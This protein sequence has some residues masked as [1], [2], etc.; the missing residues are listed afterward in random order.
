MSAAESFGEVFREMN[1]WGFEPVAVEPPGRAWK[2]T[3]RCRD[4][5]ILIE[6]HV[7]DWQFIQYPKISV[8]SAFND[9]RLRPHLSTQRTLCY[10]QE[11]A[12]VLD[13]H[14]PAVAL[15]QC[16]AQAQSVLSRL[17]FDTDSMRADLLEEFETYWL[18]ETQ[19][20][21]RV[22]LASVPSK[23]ASGFWRTTFWTL[24]YADGSLCILSDN[25]AE[26]SKISHSF[27]ASKFRDTKAPCWLFSTAA[28]PAIPE[29]LPSTVKELFSWLRLWDAE[30]YRHFQDLLGHEVDYIKFQRASFAITSPAGWL[31]FSF[32]IDVP[33][34]KIAKRS[35]RLYRNFLHN[36]GK[37]TP[38]FKFSVYDLSSNFLHSRN[39]TYR[40]LAG[41][42]VK[43]IGCGAIGSFASEA[44]VRLGAGSSGGQLDLIDPGVLLPE[45]LGRHILGFSDLF[46]PKA[47]RLARH[48][49]EKFP[50]SR[51]LPHLSSAL[52]L[53]DVFEADVLVDAAGEE[54]VSTALNS[55]HM[56]QA[57]DV[58]MVHVW[59][60]GNGEAVQAL[61][62]GGSKFACYRCL[63]ILGPDG[64][65]RDRFEVL[66][67]ETVRRQIGC[68][69]F[70]PYAVSSPL[71][72][73]GLAT[74]M[75]SDWLKR[76]EPSPRFR[77]I[78][79]DGAEARVVKNK[80]VLRLEGCPACS[81][82]N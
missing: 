17:L 20:H 21:S 26:V 14:R 53:E 82:A 36:G 19:E 44:L 12:V 4:V 72:A 27:G 30:L 42:R 7:T 55:L 29:K 60:L 8:L 48:L 54:A 33:Q 75:I 23:P 2:G 43:L 6:L 38:I 65:L 64:V 10:F 50:L 66:K 16:L 68:H 69:A 57:Q 40:S 76:S 11:G 46:E 18:Q 24:E 49:E 13:M 32:N 34:S 67:T 74:A 70:T 71:H 47:I 1:R 31:G 15:A 62:V 25:P 56:R 80:N 59:I 73:A 9:S 39:L 52:V 58:P 3:I 22:L 79:A 77:T 81:D 35:V 78:A 45:N 37:D 28:S 61:W 63:R 41:L 5:S 51:I